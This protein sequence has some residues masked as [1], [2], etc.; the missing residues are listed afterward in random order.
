MYK[1][2]ELKEGTEIDLPGI[3]FCRVTKLY[4]NGAVVVR[5][6]D[7]QQWLCQ[8]DFLEQAEISLFNFE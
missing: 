2:A 4:P 5:G 8:R 7:D 6:H 1:I 3:G